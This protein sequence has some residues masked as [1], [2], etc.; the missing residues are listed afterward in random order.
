MFVARGSKFQ[1]IARYALQNAKYATKKG[2]FHHRCHHT[3]VYSIYDLLST[4]T[5]P[6]SCC[7]SANQPDSV[8]R[9]AVHTAGSSS[10]L[11]SVGH[12]MRTSFHVT[13]TEIQPRSD[14]NGLYLETLLTRLGLPEPLRR[15]TYR[16]IHP[17]A[18]LSP[19]SIS[20]SAFFTSNFGVSLR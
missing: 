20:Q 18:N 9:F 16:Y 10:T 7:S 11:A 14:S 3:K 4:D 6:L 1:K 2:A 17:N 13:S 8:H 15:I 5:W 19:S 12:H